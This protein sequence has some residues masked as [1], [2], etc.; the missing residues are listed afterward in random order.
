MGEEDAGKEKKKERKKRKRKKKKKRNFARIRTIDLARFR[1][2]S[3]FPV[4]LG[5]VRLCKDLG[6]LAALV[7]LELTSSK[8]S[9]SKA[10]EPDSDGPSAVD[11]ASPDFV[12]LVGVR[13]C[14]VSKDGL[15]GS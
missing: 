8:S 7:P 6:S 4:R 10:W 2:S 11:G 13:K 5:G 3:F 14:M 9:Y 15:Q 12:F 1:E